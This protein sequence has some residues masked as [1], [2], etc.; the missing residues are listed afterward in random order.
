[1]HVASSPRRAETC[2]GARRGRTLSSSL[3]SLPHPTHLKS[4]SK[5]AVDLNGWSWESRHVALPSI[6]VCAVGFYTTSSSTDI[7]TGECLKQVW[8]C[9]VTECFVHGPSLTLLM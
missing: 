8:R 1:M 3:H 4:V 2:T 7:F 6:R 9:Q 5:Q